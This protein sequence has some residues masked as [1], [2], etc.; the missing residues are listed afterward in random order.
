[1]FLNCGI[2]EPALAGFEN[3]FNPRTKVHSRGPGMQLSTAR[4]KVSQSPS[5]QH[6]AL[7]IC[8][9]E[10]QSRCGAA[11]QCVQLQVPAYVPLVI[12]TFLFVFLIMARQYCR[13]RLWFNWTVTKQEVDGEQ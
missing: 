9:H 8:D 4:L 13:G 5:Q 10:R 7:A 2:M 3:R 11:G 1:M 12:F 6:W